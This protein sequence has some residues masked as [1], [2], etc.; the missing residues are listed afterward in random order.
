MKHRLVIGIGDPSQGDA[1]AGPVV[2]AHMRRIGLAVLTHDG[3]G[4]NLMESWAGYN[5]VVLVSVTRSGI[6][7]GTVRTFNVIA[8]DLPTSLFPRCAH[9]IGPAEAIETARVQGRLPKMLA[10]VGIEGMAFSE[11]G[12]LSAAVEAAVPLAMAEVE[13]FL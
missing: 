5:R 12:Q 3:E 2:A 10:L 9:A 7:P 13:R 11:G 8:S 4:R 1:G 6:A